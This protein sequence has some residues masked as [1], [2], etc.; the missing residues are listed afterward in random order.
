M[1]I[2]KIK[3]KPSAVR[4]LRRLG[5]EAQEQ[6]AAKIDSLA[7]DPLPVGC[8]KLE[9]KGSLYRVRTADYR[10]IYTVERKSLTV[11]VLRIRHRKDAY[12]NL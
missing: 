3:L 7:R 9:A 6:V 11:L 5:R 10:I 2:F 4:D 12:R 8:E 1:A